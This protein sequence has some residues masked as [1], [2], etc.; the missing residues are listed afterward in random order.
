MSICWVFLSGVFPLTEE[1]PPKI[2]SGDQIISL[3]GLANKYVFCSSIDNLAD[4]VNHSGLID[5]KRRHAWPSINAN[6]YNYPW[7]FS[8]C[9]DGAA[10]F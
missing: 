2:I 4:A 8:H 3:L 7:A 6:P 9:R 1:T 5:S 10:I